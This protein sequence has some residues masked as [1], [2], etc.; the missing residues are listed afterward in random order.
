MCEFNEIEFG[1]IF[2]HRVQGAVG[3][4]LH[5]VTGGQGAPVLLVPGW[6]QT[7]YAWRHVMPLLAKR[8]TVVAVDL[9]GMG[10]SDKPIDGY[11]TGT[12]AMRLHDLTRALG[13]RQFDFVG[14]DIG[15]W[16]GYPFVATYPDSVR[17]L[18]LIDA[19]VPGLAPAEA[20]AFAPERIGRNWHFFFNA[21]SDLPETLLAGREREFLSWLFQAKAS[22]PAAISQQAMDEYVRCYEAPGAWRCANSYYRAYFDDMAQN[23]EHARRKIRTPILTVGGDVGLGSMMEPMMRPVAEDVTGL[24]V[25][26]CGHYVPEE[27]P[28]FLAEHLINFLSK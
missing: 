1:R 25:P 7:W 26:D 24:V 4:R 6:P 12:V 14:H 9:P 16:L 13:W 10:D 22:N 3:N 23:R 17:K 15:C 2:Q 27:A 5:Y 8:F 11:D 21:L 18:A 19:T 20:Y 28:N